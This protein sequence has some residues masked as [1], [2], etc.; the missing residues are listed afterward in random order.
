MNILA[1]VTFY[2]ISGTSGDQISRGYRGLNE[3]VDFVSDV[4]QII[5]ISYTI[6]PIVDDNRPMMYMAVTILFEYSE[7]A[8]SIPALKEC[9]L[10][11]QTVFKTDL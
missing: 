9:M 3:K 4:A 7:Q 10:G 5:S 6:T 2:G 11:V 8:S 1:V